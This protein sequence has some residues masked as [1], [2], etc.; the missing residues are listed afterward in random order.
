MNFCNHEYSR[1]IT[2]Q[3]IL[4]RYVLGGRG[5]LTLLNPETKIHH[6]YTFRRPDDASPYPND[7]LFVYAVHNNSKLLYVG[8]VESGLFRLT[9]NS[10]FISDTPIVRG[11]RY[12]M[13]LISDDHVFSITKMQ[14][15]HEG[16]CAIC[17]RPLTGEHSLEEGVG[18]KCINRTMI[19]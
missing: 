8:M 2:D 7:I 13:R 17:G 19:S 9:K 5:V 15:Y 18:P 6:T 11:A 14:I 1:R 16:V 10:R 4:R 3:N 12:I